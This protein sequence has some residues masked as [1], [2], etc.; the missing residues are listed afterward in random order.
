[1]G[2][3]GRTSLARILT[4]SVVL[5]GLSLAAAAGPARAQA[6]RTMAAATTTARRSPARHARGDA[7]VPGWVLVRFEGGAG[8]RGRRAAAAA[9]DGEVLAGSGRTRVVRLDRGADVRAAARRLAGRPGVASAEPD[10]LR[11]VDDCDPDICW[12]LQPNQG[13]EHGADVVAAHDAGATGTGR[14]VAV[15][16]TGVREA[17][18]DDPHTGADEADDLD[19]GDRIAARWRCRDT[20]CV[21]A[22]ATPTSSHGT[23]VAS[24]IVAADDGDGT[25]GVAPGATVVSYRVDSTGG[26]IPISYLR[27]ALLH[28]AAD[29]IDVVNLSLGGSQGPRPS[30]R[31]STPSWPPAG[32]WSPRPATPA[33]ASPSTRPPSR[34]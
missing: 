28:I 4:L 30:R 32:P 16:D 22:V 23:E 21:P 17:I 19:L 31:G 34:A 3:P 14:T 9:V 13:A 18:P 5:S 15:V 11:R 26:G 12:H 25:T 29:D 20:G 10:W 8:E 1:M 6:Q 24:V 7:F 27:Q 33:T 2:M